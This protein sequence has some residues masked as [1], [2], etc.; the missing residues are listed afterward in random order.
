MKRIG[1]ILLCAVLCMAVLVLGGCKLFD[2]EAVRARTVAML[3]AVVANDAE[4]AYAC[5][6]AEVSREEF[7]T[8]F[9][10]FRTLLGDTASYTL[11]ARF[12]EMK[13]ERGVTVTKVQYRMVTDKAVYAVESVTD[14]RYDGLYHFSLA[15]AG[16]FEL[17]A[18]PIGSHPLQIV[19]L[20]VAL[21]ETAFVVWMM[22]D[23]ARRRVKHK[24]LW[25]IV[26]LFGMLMVTFTM[27]DGA[28]SLRTGF[29]FL[30][31]FTSLNI[32]GTFV[33]A[34]LLFPVGAVVYACMRKRLTLPEPMP[35]LT[36]MPEYLQQPPQA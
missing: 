3:D 13:T 17:A 26:I 15:P 12:M 18:T 34:R 9:A 6:V 36:P 29:G 1:Q 31:S 11:N 33:S 20:I 2:N 14:S 27:N 16:G 35:E 5:M 8:A 21:A 23:C 22:V 4:A 25:L 32:Y 10:Q 19:F 28:A 7:D 24:A 30:L